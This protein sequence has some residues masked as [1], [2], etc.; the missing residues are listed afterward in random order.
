[1]RRTQYEH[2]ES[3]M[4]PKLSVKRSSPIDG[5]GQKRVFSREIL[6]RDAGSSCPHS[7]AAVNIGRRDNKR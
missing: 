2:I 3:A 6:Y 5:M 4:P 7:A 1:M